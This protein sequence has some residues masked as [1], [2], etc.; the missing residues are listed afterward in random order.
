MTLTKKRNENKS[1]KTILTTF[2][3]HIEKYWNANL[4]KPVSFLRVSFKCDKNDYNNSYPIFKKLIQKI[5]Y[6]YKTYYNDYLK[7][8]QNMDNSISNIKR[9]CN[10][11]LMDSN[12]PNE[13]LPIIYVILSVCFLDSTQKHNLQKDSD[14]S[15][16]YIAVPSYKHKVI[17]FNILLFDFIEI[18]YIS[19]IDI[20]GIDLIKNHNS[21]GL[22]DDLKRISEIIEVFRKSPELILPF[23]MQPID[24]EKELTKIVDRFF[25]DNIKS[26]YENNKGNRSYFQSNNK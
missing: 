25:I 8:K 12:I 22:L 19:L 10:P 2:I 26:N 14:K 24:G 17:S 6:F 15:L 7:Y 20:L 5:N 18:D 1:L 9:L 13:M 11:I 21:N 4:N 3:K 23:S 16:S